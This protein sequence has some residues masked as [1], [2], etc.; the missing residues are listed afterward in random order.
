MFFLSNKRTVGRMRL[1]I[2]DALCLFLLFFGVGG[3]LRDIERLL[4]YFYVVLV[5]LVPFFQDFCDS[6]SGLGV[7]NV[8]RFAGHHKPTPPLLSWKVVGHLFLDQFPRDGKFSHQMIVPLAP[9]FVSN[10]G[11]ECL[12]ACVNISNL[13]RSEGGRPALLRFSEM[14]TLFHEFLA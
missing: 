13:P 4:L 14:K 12:P 6:R 3:G 11:E 5:F 7:S 10:S 1:E 8:N 9:A 2:I